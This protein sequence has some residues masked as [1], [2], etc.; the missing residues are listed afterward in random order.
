MSMTDLTYNEAGYAFVPDKELTKYLHEDTI[1]W[2]GSSLKGLTRNYI[3]LQVHHKI[4]GHV[5]NLLF[6]TATQQPVD[7]LGLGLE[8]CA[9]KIDI[10]KLKFSSENEE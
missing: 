8:Q 2:N 9:C 1:Q 10:I 6:D 5:S 3:V 4:D 7:E